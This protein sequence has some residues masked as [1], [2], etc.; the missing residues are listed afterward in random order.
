MTKLSFWHSAVLV[1]LLGAISWSCKPKGEVVER[2]RVT[3]N[4]NTDV[5]ID[6]VKENEFD[7]GWLTMK[8]AVAFENSK[9]S[10]SFKMLIRMKTDSVIWIS[11]T[12]YSIEVARFLITPDTVK[13]IDRKGDQFYI[14]NFSYLNEKFNVNLSFELLQSVLIGNSIGISDTTKVHSFAERGLY[15][16]ST[17]KKGQMRRIEQ[18]TRNIND[19][20]YRNSI[21]PET[22]K[23]KELSVFDLRS[24]QSMQ[25]VYKEFK[26]VGDE[27]LPVKMAMDVLSKDV[28][29]ITVS[30]SKIGNQGPYKTSFRIP[31][32]YVR[33]N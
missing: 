23:I 12:Y 10:D 3:A 32:K 21:D 30:Y 15:H 7:S 11:A 27:L 2:G 18:G 26:E 33:I 17:M 22:F 1:L 24:Q 29:K 31:E 5:L 25:V 13:M 4:R 19:I 8:A 9:M 20:A 16:L 28:T 6:K 14:G